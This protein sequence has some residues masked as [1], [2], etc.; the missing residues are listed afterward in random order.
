M[1]TYNEDSQKSPELISVVHTYY[2]SLSYINDKKVI[3]FLP[4][5]S[6]RFGA[7]YWANLINSNM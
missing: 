3:K 2:K 4:S 6:Q 1:Y 5:Y 7:K